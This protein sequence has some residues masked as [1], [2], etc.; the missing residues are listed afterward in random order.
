MPS[1][2]DYIKE[3]KRLHG[4]LEPGRAK[5]LAGE[6]LAKFQ[7]NTEGVHTLMEESYMWIG[8]ALRDEQLTR[9]GAAELQEARTDS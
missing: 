2:Y 7:P 1:R 3:I 9:D 4:L 8:K 6:K 5:D